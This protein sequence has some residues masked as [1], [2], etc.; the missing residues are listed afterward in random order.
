M[1]ILMFAR[2]PATGAF[3][4]P[5]TIQI[6]TSKTGNPTTSPSDWN[7]FSLDVTNDG[8]NGEQTHPG[9]PCFGDQPLLGIDANGVYITT[10]EFPINGPGFNGAQIYAIQKSALIA[11]TTPNVQR[12]EGLQGPVPFA[13]TNYQNGLPYSLQ[14]ALSPS[15]SDFATA[16]NGTEYLFGALEFG[17]KPFQLDNR[18]AVWAL[19]NTAS[20]NSTPNI[21]VKD[22]I[23]NSEVYGLPPSIV[24]PNGPT[25]LADSLKEHENLIDGG[26]D[27][28]QAAIYANGHLWGAS[29]TIVKTPVRGPQVGTAYYELTPSVDSSG[30][31]SGT[32]VKQGYLSVRGNSVTR[33]S[34][35]VT[36]SGKAVVGVS[37]IGPDFYPSAAY[38]TFDDSASSTPT[39]LHVA[40][41][42]TVPADGFSG[43][44]AFPPGNGVERWGDYGFAAADGNSVWVANEWIPGLNQGPDLASWGTYVSKVTP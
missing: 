22:T 1:T 9:C 21:H 41:Q 31:P 4:A 39:T 43:Y 28:M 16:N 30:V 19:T 29:D 35:A 10:N 25:P 34:I 37:L 44:H 7:F 26:D 14:P 2:D 32:W 18:L 6:A 13:T 17:K 23:V 15:A 42:A 20:L 24:Q 38:T 3:K 36:H 27:R 40:S 33:P 11:G 5:G 12:F 8:R